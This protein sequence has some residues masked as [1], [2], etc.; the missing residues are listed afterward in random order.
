MYMALIAVF[1][2]GTGKEIWDAMGYGTPDIWDAIATYLG[3]LI[4]LAWVIPNVL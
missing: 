4:L 1:A 2:V 3:A